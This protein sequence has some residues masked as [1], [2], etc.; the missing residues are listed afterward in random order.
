MTLHIHLV[1]EGP[2]RLEGAYQLRN[3]KTDYGVYQVYGRHPVV[4][5]TSLLYIGKAEEQPF[6]ARLKQEKWEEWEEGEGPVEIRVRRLFGAETPSN[7]EWGRQI[8]LVE[9]LLIAAN[10]PPRNGQGVAWLSRDAE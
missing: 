10:K 3:E 2:I 1:W 8:R 6:G 7:E 4:G 5:V 9:K